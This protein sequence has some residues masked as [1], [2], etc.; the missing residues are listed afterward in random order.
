MA[1][2]SIVHDVYGYQ[3][4]TGFSLLLSYHFEVPWIEGRLM[5]IGSKLLEC[6]SP[7]TRRGP[8]GPQILHSFSKRNIV[9]S[10]ARRRLGKDEIIVARLSIISWSDIF[11]SCANMATPTSCVV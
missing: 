9:V 8:S 7:Y 3:L 4:G 5:R 6:E 2:N 10:L 1:S 11:I